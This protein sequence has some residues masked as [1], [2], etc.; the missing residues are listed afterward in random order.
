MN[1]GTWY[2]RSRQEGTFG[3]FSWTLGNLSCVL[4]A[5]ICLTPPHVF[6][7]SPTQTFLHC[8]GASSP[9]SRMGSSASKKAVAESTHAA[10]ARGGKLSVREVQTLA[11]GKTRLVVWRPMFPGRQLLAQRQCICSTVRAPVISPLQ[12]TSNNA[13]GVTRMSAS[14]VWGIF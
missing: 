4:A 5:C 1:G 8:R 3:V 10:K 6:A 14:L 12:Q 11:G 9:R 7:I 13:G 2:E